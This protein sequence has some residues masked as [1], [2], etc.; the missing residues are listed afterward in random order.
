MQC[1]DLRPRILA[2]VL[3]AMGVLE[4]GAAHANL[5]GDTVDITLASPVDSINLTDS[6]VT[7]VDPGKEIQTGDNSVIG[8]DGSAGSSPMLSEEFL[9]IQADRII[10]QLEAG[11]VDGNENLLTGYA[12]GAYWQIAGLDFAGGTITGF[13]LFLTG[14]SNFTAANDIIFSG[15]NTF[16]IFISNLF[17]ANSNTG[18]DVGQIELRLLTNGTQPPS[19]PEPG[20]LAL[21]GLGLATF[22]GVRRRRPR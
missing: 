4:S 22:A 21:L 13:D 5:I 18:I 2:G 6:N 19:V 7:V 9:D 12:P 3:V 8:G 17:I 20:T 10:L 15:G 11:G 14:I 1:H 16:K